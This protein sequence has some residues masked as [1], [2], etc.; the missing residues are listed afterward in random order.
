MA[1]AA[2]AAATFSA[3]DGQGLLGP[4]NTNNNEDEVVEGGEGVFKVGL[5]LPKE[6]SGE[7]GFSKELT[8]QLRALGSLGKLLAKRS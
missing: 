7:G 5:R 2:A 8:I 6:V 1:A 4:D 3:G